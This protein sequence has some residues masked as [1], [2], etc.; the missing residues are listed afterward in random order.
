MK[1]TASLLLTIF[2]ISCSQIFSLNPAAYFELVNDA[3]IAICGK[4]YQKALDHY[5]AAFPTVEKP[6]GKDV[7]NAALASQLALD[8]QKRD[9][10]LQIIINNTDDLAYVKS[11]FVGE[12][13]DEAGWEQLVSKR[14]IAYDPALRSQ[15][16]EILA[17][18]QAFRPDYD[19][20][21]D[22]INANRKINL[23]LI[24]EYGDKLNKFPSQ[25]EIGYGSP[26]RSQPH[27]IVLYH[28]AQRRSD[29]KSVIDLEPIL[30][31]AVKDGG[32]DPEKA[33]L[34]LNFQN[35]TEK[36]PYEVY[37]SWQFYHPLLPDSLNDKVWYPQLD[38]AQKQAANEM[39]ESWC[40]NSL[41]DISLK[42]D[43]VSKSQYPFMF[44]A[45]R[46]ST[47][48]LEDHLDAEGALQQYQAFVS[49][50]LGQ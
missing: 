25:I 11:V 44:S 41:E 22:T 37:S 40:A 49:M 17:R 20:Y 8:Y 5:E 27:H 10:Y 33:I 26:L 43:Y 28:T 15:F 13:M 36:G 46:S 45:V 50:M 18:D 39:R 38:E 47:A 4:R 31:L 30:R 14:I 7:F 35:D 32:L 23:Q 21:D 3:E 1:I 9:A 24:E 12:Y 6:F 2:F 42:T 16:E 29:D 48:N 34:Y 19:A